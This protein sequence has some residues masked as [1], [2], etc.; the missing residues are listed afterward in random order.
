MS[1]RPKL[2]HLIVSVGAV[3]F[4]WSVAALPVKDPNLESTADSQLNSKLISLH[5]R[6]NGLKTSKIQQNF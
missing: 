3:L 6:L 5:Y 2:G 4:L 1:T